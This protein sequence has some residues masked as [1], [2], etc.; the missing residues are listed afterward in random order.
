MRAS[1]HGSSP[2]AP[3]TTVRRRLGLPLGLERGPEPLVLLGIFA[4]DEGAA[5]R[6]P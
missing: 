3:D 5:A 1:S 2:F 4:V 6:R